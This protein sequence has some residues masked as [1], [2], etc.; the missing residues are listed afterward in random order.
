M[1]VRSVPSQVQRH[2][3]QPLQPTANA[4]PSSRSTATSEEV[5]RAGAWVFRLVVSEG[6]QAAAVAEYAVLRAGCRRL[7]IIHPHTLAG[8]RRGQPVQGH[9]RE[10]RSELSS[11]PRAI[12]AEQPTSGPRS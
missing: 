1:G 8:E 10:P 2:S 7:A 12:R 6:D 11:P 4:F 5:D 9:G 3:R